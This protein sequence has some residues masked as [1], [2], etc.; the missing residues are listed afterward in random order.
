[1]PFPDTTGWVP[2]QELSGVG[3]SPQPPQYIL[4]AMGGAYDQSRYYWNPD[5]M[6]LVDRYTGGSY[7]YGD[8]PDPSQG[9]NVVTDLSGYNANGP[10]DPGTFNF[11][12]GVNPY[13]AFPG[14]TYNAG[15]TP[16]SGLFLSA[17]PNEIADYGDARRDRNW[18]GIGQVG[19]LVGG[20]AALG[21]TQWGSGATAGTGG[22]TTGAATTYPYVTGGTITGSAIPGVTSAT[23]AANAAAAGIGPIVGAGTGATNLLDQSTQGP[24][25]PSGPSNA[26][27]NVPD[28]VTNYLLPGVNS[29]LGANAAN[30]ASDAQVAALDRAIAENAR[31]YD[32]TRMDLMPWLD[33]GKNALT[34]LNDPGN[35][36][37]A[38][39]DYNFVRGEGE[40]DIGNSFAARGGALSG[41]ALRALTEFNSNLASGEFNNWWNR[42]AGRAGVGQNT[43]VNLGSLG[44]DSA[45]TAGNYLTNQG[46]ARASG[47]LGKYSSVANGLN[48]GIY[49]YLYRR[50]AA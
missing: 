17:D 20:A 12:P 14:E 48:D 22:A 6:S 30:Q 24:P 27:S 1:M 44:A 28:W 7:G 42:Q 11:A 41:N 13:I 2:Q 43:A 49:N 21:G 9:T 31:Q 47:V 5:T 50:R 19:A 45:R 15:L 10:S 26:L 23:T 16:N 3:S 39:P 18:Q 36:F 40:R 46:T 29:L 4:D 33:A 37:T 38:S 25:I 34:Q 35:Y 32:T 8:I